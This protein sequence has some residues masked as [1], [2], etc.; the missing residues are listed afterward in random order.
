MSRWSSRYDLSGGGVAEWLYPDLVEIGSL[1]ELTAE[2]A[3]HLVRLA[4]ENGATSEGKEVR[5]S[6]TGTRWT[7]WLDHEPA[8]DD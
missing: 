4:R 6:R 7:V 3:H 8:D 2:E 5:A 1:E